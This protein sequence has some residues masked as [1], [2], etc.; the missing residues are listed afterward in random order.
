MERGRKPFKGLHLISS[1]PRSSSIAGLWSIHAAK[2]YQVGSEKLPIGHVIYSRPSSL[3]GFWMCV[4]N[5][6]LFFEQCCY[7]SLAVC[8]HLSHSSLFASGTWAISPSFQGERH[9][10]VFWV[11]PR[12]DLVSTPI[13]VIMGPSF[14]QVS[15]PLS[16]AQLP[17]ISAGWLISK[18]P[19]QH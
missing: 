1:G 2:K 8:C 15:F 16:A 9:S 5:T 7:Q 12:V 6:S 13:S 17:S 11:E 3:V 18:E 4:P 19:F 14:R 10:L